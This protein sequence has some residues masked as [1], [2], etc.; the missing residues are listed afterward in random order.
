MK[1]NLTATSDDDK[2]IFITAGDGF[3]QSIFLQYGITYDDSV[4]SVRDGGFG[5]TGR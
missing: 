3:V 5:S 1:R 4:S 2:T